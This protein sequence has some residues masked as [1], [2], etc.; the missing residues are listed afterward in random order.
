M[1][2]YAMTVLNTGLNTNLM[3]AG[4]ANVLLD[5]A[6]QLRETASR[7]FIR[8]IELGTIHIG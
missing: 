7:T 6:S 8:R 2:I 4:A 5:Y 1:R 3:D